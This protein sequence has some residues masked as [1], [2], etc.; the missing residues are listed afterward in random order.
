MT[1]QTASTFVGPIQGTVLGFYFGAASGARIAHQATKEKAAVKQ[2]CDE[3]M[4]NCDR[5]VESVIKHPGMRTMDEQPIEML[6]AVYRSLD[7][8]RHAINAM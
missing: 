3:V 8:T 5:D 7:N 6:E 2:M 4:G 1:A